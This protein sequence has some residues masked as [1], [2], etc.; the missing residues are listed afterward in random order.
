MNGVGLQTTW[1]EIVPA[2]HQ[3]VASGVMTSLD[4]MTKSKFYE[5]CKYLYLV[6]LII[7]EHHV[8][9]SSKALSNLPQE[10]KQILIEELTRAEQL[11]WGKLI[12][13]NKGHEES[14]EV[15]R[16]YGATII[17]LNPDEAVTMRNKI[18]TSLGRVEQIH[19]G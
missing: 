2:L 7:A 19:W 14:I 15:W 5:I 13:K 16:K 6:N 12:P 10:Y 8:F 9:V 3:G 1:A 18:K 17:E 11:N 4:S